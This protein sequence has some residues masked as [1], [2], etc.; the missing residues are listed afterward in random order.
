MGVLD[1]IFLQFQSAF[2]EKDN[3][4]PIDWL[5]AA[6][7]DIG[8]YTAFLNLQYYT[9]PG[10][11]VLCCF[12]GSSQARQS[13][14]QPEE[15]V[16]E[17]LLTMLSSHFGDQVRSQFVAAFRTRWSSDPFARGSYSFVKLGTLPRHFEDIGEP[18]HDILLFAGEASIRNHFS[19]VHGAYFS[20]LREG[21]RIAEMFNIPQ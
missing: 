12:T 9:G 4:K 10:V 3:D 15:A 18:A 8:I 14:S 5:L 21:K 13:E 20:G 19:T 11:P 2:W 1:K 6:P 16:V 7:K 17:H